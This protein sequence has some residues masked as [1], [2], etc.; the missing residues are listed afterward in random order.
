MSSDHQSRRPRT[1]R[2]D[3]PTAVAEAGVARVPPTSTAARALRRPH[4]RSLIR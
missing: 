4:E 3:R 2:T 1:G